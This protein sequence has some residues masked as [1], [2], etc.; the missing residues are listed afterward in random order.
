MTLNSSS[1]LL[2]KVFLELSKIVNFVFSSSF[3][4]TKNQLNPSDFFLFK[5]I[6]ILGEQLSLK[7]FFVYYDFQAGSGL[8]LFAKMGIIFTAPC[9]TRVRDMKTT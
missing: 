7:T 4:N 5:N 2:Q 8:M 1:Y 3:F 9:I 6:R